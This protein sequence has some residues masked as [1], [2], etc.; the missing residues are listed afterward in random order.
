MTFASVTKLTTVLALAGLSAPSFAQE[1]QE[2]VVTAQKRSENI[3]DVPISITAL[4]GAQMN[5]LGFISTDDIQAAVP[6]LIMSRP[7]GDSLA[8]L[9]AIRGVSQNDFAEHQETSTATYVDGAYFSL[10]RA[11]TT[12][13]YDMERVEVL[14]GPQGTL[15]G[16]NANGGLIQYITR[17]P[18]SQFDA[19]V[20]LTAGS[21]NQAR[22]E[23][24]IGGPLGGGFQA[25]LAGDFN[26]NSGVTE[27][28][29]GPSLGST[30]YRGFR[31][32]LRYVS[33]PFDATL[34]YSYGR[35]PSPT[36]GNYHHQ[37]AYPNAQGLGVNLPP[38]QNY[39]G[40]CNGCDILGY[41]GP[42]NVHQGSYDA[43]GYLDRTTWYSTLTAAYHANDHLTFTSITNYL[44][45][46]HDY[47]QDADA[48]PNA[49]LNFY[50]WQTAHQ[51]SEELRANGDAS[52]TRWVAGVYYLSID[53]TNSTL[54]SAPVFDGTPYA[55]SV[56]ATFPTTTKNYSVFAQADFDLTKAWYVTVGARYSHDEKTINFNLYDEATGGNNIFPYQGDRN[57][58]GVSAKLQLNYHPSEQL[59]LYGGATRGTKAGGFNAP[60]G[61]PIPAN[62]MAFNGEVLTDY[63]IGL[64]L[65]T[66]QVQ[67]NANAFYYHYQDYQAFDLLNL[68]SVV[69]NHPAQMYGFDTDLIMSPARGLE[70]IL[71]GTLLYSNVDNI[72]LP[73]GA[74]VDAAPPQAPRYSVNSLLRKTW[75]I[76]SY[77]FTA[78]ADF[79]YLDHFYSSVSNAPN[80]LVPGA[81]V[82]GAL[83]SFGS[84]DGNWQ[85]SVIGR[86]LLNRDVMQL[87]YDL[88]SFGITEQVYLPARW[89]SGEFTYRWR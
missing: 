10:I 52:W 19:Y 7:G 77:A 13:M 85:F 75:D 51:V 56:A 23:A 48:S 47:L 71:G 53:E 6:G 36:A 1:L 27:N 62:E 74:V 37:S 3:Q 69:S 32:E 9:P 60:Y 38:N 18:S 2:I 14:R 16:R 22:V 57:F 59:L 49:L 5:Q 34:S 24:A 35:D 86:N 61:G 80:T 20:D 87:A 88:S 79:R 11:L 26:D 54:T 73:N 55:Y 89:I 45:T 76:Q 83:L 28:F 17:Q 44:W 68:T 12:D 63:E 81:G 84:R 4:T 33:G 58:E 43:I 30:K 66:P 70:F 8:S 78:Q 64:K 50:E 39:W 82:L 25:R 65:T 15:F 21:F 31:A 46:N 40:T 29:I 42:T 72:V 41:I 67:W